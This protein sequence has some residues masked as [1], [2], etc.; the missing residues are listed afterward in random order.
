MND[1]SSLRV[2]GRLVKEYLSK[3]E[4]RVGEAAAAGAE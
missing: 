2:Q 3:E 4:N 1:P